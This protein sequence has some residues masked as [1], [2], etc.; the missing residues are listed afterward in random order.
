M[1]T[2]LAVPELPG[3]LYRSPSRAACTSR[4]GGQLGG[5]LGGP[6]SWWVVQVTWGP[7][8]CCC[9]RADC[10]LLIPGRACCCWTLQATP[11]R[12]R[13]RSAACGGTSI[14]RCTIRAG[15]ARSFIAGI[16]SVF[17]QQLQALVPDGS[18]Q[19]VRTGP[20]GVS[21]CETLPCK[22]AATRTAASSD[23]PTGHATKSEP[24]YLV[25]TSVT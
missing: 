25:V 13:L 21:V 3:V 15:P 4:A 18:L 12:L 9:W 2:P 6:C 5:R 20:A 23:S 8:P 1:V 11:R 22:D 16:D 19:P 24:A 14:H 10:V 17:Q 7:R